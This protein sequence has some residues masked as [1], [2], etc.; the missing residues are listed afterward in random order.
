MFFLQFGT[1]HIDSC[2]GKEINGYFIENV[3]G[4]M[5][6]FEINHNSFPYLFPCNQS[7][8]KE[9]D[10]GSEISQFSSGLG[11]ASSQPSFFIR[12]IIGWRCTS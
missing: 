3:V 2:F 4:S 1:G 8:H 11:S 12:D 5:V 10:R 9:K 7:Y 6:L